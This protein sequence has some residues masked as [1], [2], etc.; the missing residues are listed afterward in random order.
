MLQR[1]QALRMKAGARCRPLLSEERL[2][3]KQISQLLTCRMAVD[4]R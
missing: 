2:I 1:Y 4:A 3:F